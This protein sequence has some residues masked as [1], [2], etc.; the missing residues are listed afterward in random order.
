MAPLGLV[1]VELKVETTFVPLSPVQSSVLLYKV[2]VDLF[3]DDTQFQGLQLSLSLDFSALI[4][5]VTLNGCT[6]PKGLL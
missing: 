1:F 5:R 4:C 6:K 2:L 3:C